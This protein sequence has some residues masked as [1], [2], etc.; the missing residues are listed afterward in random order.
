MCGCLGWACSSSSDKQEAIQIS[1]LIY[2]EEGQEERVN[3][4]LQAFRA[5]SVSLAEM[6]WENEEED[7]YSSWLQVSIANSKK[8]S[9]RTPA[10]QEEICRRM[11]QFL[12]EHLAYSTYYD[13]CQVILSTA[14][15]GGQTEES[16]SQVF[17]FLPAELGREDTEV[18]FE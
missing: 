15:R 10:E 9:L 8:L 2:V 13:S 18:D 17:S 1:D 7:E 11:S 6:S 14:R 16:S 4:Y 12:M 3:S 5:R